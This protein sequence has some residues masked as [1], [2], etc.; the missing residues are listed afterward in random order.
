MCYN[1]FNFVSKSW[2][3]VTLDLSSTITPTANFTVNKPSEIKEGQAYVLRVNNWATAY[4]MTLG[5]GINNPF[6][7]DLSLTTNWTDQ[8]IFYA[9]SSNTLELQ[10]NWT[11]IKY[12]TESEYNNLPNSKLTNWISYF[13]YKAV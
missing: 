2:A 12:V 5:T 11:D 6:W 8:F 3:T 4:T 13:I 7:V 1:D 10:N 9:I